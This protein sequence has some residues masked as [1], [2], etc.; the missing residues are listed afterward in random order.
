MNPLMI[1]VKGI[2]GIKY[3]SAKN[4]DK[5]AKLYNSNLD[6]V[7]LIFLDVIGSFILI[8]LEIP[9]MKSINIKIDRVITIG[10]SGD[11][12]SRMD[13]KN[14]IRNVFNID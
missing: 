2:N 13:A 8:A 1:L 9:V 5:I 7:K 4:P 6:T 14:L 11:N 10:C 3:V 12:T